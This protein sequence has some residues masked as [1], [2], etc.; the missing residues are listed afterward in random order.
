[1]RLVNYLAASI[2]PTRSL[3]LSKLNSLLE[4][5]FNKETRTNIRVRVLD[6]LSNVI[7]A[8]RYAYLSVHKLI[9]QVLITHFHVRAF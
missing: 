8:N 9:L 5:Y 4:K 6:I 7:Q 1:L 3:W 2:I